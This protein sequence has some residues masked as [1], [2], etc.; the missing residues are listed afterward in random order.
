M[1]VC[2]RVLLRVCESIFQSVE[3]PNRGINPVTLIRSGAQGSRRHKSYS[4][5]GTQWKSKTFTLP[6]FFYVFVLQLPHLGIASLCK[7]Q[8]IGPFSIS[9]ISFHSEILLILL[10]LLI[11]EMWLLFLINNTLKI[12][13][14]TTKVLNENSIFMLILKCLKGQPRYLIVTYSVQIHEIMQVHWPK[15]LQESSFF[16]VIPFSLPAQI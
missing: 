15:T 11:C 12:L 8:F 2:G 13:G 3:T 4:I 9:K 7:I 16:I 10:F 6:I 14:I 5:I 1:C